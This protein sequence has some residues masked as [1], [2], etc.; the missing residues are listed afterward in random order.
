VC[1]GVVRHCRHIAAE[2]LSALHSK[3][4]ASGRKPASAALPW[5][6]PIDLNAIGT[7][8]EF[9]TRLDK[10][11]D[12]FRRE[13][14]AIAVFGGG[15]TALAIAV[16]LWMDPAFFYPRIQTDPLNYYLKAKAFVETGTTAARWAVNLHPFPYA[17]MPGVLR[18]PAIYFF[19]DFDDQLRMMQLMNI[20]PV[21]GV[22]LLSAYILSWSVPRRHHAMVIAFSFAFTMLSPIWMANLFLP[23]ADAPYAF[24]TLAAIVISRN[25]LCSPRQLREQRMALAAL[26]VLFA[27]SFT[28]RFTGP[29]VLA[30]AAVLARGRWT[31]GHL[32]RRHVL[33]GGVAI[34]VVLLA[35]VAFNAEAIFGRYFFEPIFYLVKA[36][37]P[38]MILNLL[39]SAI[40]AEIVPN[41]Q[42]G[43]RTPTLVNHY[44]TQFAATPIDALWMLI[45][46]GIS[47]LV[48]AG[49]W[50]ARNKLLPEIA[51]VLIPLPVLA[52]VLPSTS[53]YLMTYQPFFWVFFYYGLV[54]FIERSGFT[55][56]AWMQ[57]RTLAAVAV[58]AIGA[59]TVGL[60]MWRTAGTGAVKELAVHFTD[61]PAYVAD[62]ATTFRK[63]RGYIET[64]PADDALLISEWGSS[65][66]WDVIS[67]R[68]YY[69]PDPALPQML[70]DHSVY[71]LVECGTQE[72]CQDWMTFR[73]LMERRVDE[74]GD[75]DYT[76]VFSYVT[77][78]ARAEVLRI[79]AKPLLE[80]KTSG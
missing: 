51:Y 76:P 66:R 58:V 9:H 55:R 33:Q 14:I 32:S 35:L 25:I 6:Q 16:I 74:F 27:I 8:Y 50:S 40:P 73:I 61:V 41:F 1:V 79:T 47:G 37:R 20:I 45:G 44:Y 64:L 38:G 2:V 63:L 62:V 24:F 30:F 3:G 31:G 70:P 29:V 57:T 59:I 26:F 36:D 5:K 23:L 77:P 46:I 18:A 22:A 68:H 28:L 13:R 54:A 21:G 15:F 10:P 80:T 53:R 12:F 19:A 60:R 39:S 11:L 71:L 49:M 48:F 7:S 67:G 4:S 72:S 17:A 42:L 75:F 52:V 78:H 34:L 65:G 69:L 43:F 56:P